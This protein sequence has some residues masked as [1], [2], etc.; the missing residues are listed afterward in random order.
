MNERRAY[1]AGGH[2]YCR[3]NGRDQD[4]LECGTCPRLA[5]VNTETSPPYIVCELSRQVGGI[6]S[7]DPGFSEWWYRHHRRGR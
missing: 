5:A 2:V 3:E 6:F 1:I 7:D 4:V